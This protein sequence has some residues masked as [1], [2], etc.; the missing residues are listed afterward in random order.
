LKA[1]PL[2][3][4]AVAYRSG[5]ARRGALLPVVNFQEVAASGAPTE[6]LMPLVR[7]TEYTASG[8]RGA[9]GRSAARRLEEA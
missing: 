6:S 7:C 3:A 5:P 1:E 9:F 4:A 2:T 8:A